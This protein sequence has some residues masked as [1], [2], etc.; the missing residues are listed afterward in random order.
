MI[1]CLKLWNI[2][3]RV[4]LRF[5]GYPEQVHGLS[6]AIFGGS[7]IETEIE[8]HRIVIYSFVKGYRKKFTHDGIYAEV[9]ITAV[10]DDK[11]DNAGEEN[12]DD[13]ADKSAQLKRKYVFCDMDDKKS[14]FSEFD[15]KVSEFLY[16]TSIQ[17]CGMA[18]IMRCGYDMHPK[19]YF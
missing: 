6:D 17:K 15:S 1:D 9:T 7:S 8:N 19:S 11:S 13:S 4:D 18:D 2:S 14:L 16:K 5:E 3:Y 12:E 10:D